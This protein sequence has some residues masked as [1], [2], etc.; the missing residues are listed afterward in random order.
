MKQM[1][2]Q[3]NFPCPNLINNTQVLANVD[4]ELDQRLCL[5]R[6]RDFLKAQHVLL[7]RV[8][9]RGW[10]CEQKHCMG[11]TGGPRVLDPEVDVEGEVLTAV[12]VLG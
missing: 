7:G 6:Q 10:A 5:G 8:V 4:R 2:T 1:V 9:D 3:S 11:P 12:L